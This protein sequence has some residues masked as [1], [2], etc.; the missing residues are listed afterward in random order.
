MGR[1]LEELVGA[2][3]M[4]GD[5]SSGAVAESFATAA[6]EDAEAQELAES[7]AYGWPAVHDEPTLPRAPGRFAKSFPLK[8][9]M[10]VA[11][12]YEERDVPMTPAEYTQHL[13]RLP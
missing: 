4:F 6:T 12:L 2:A 8:F 13:F 5:A 11:D 9:P 3:N 10:G 7:L 1:V